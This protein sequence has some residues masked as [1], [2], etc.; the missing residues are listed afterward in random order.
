SLATAA[1]TLSPQQT[2]AGTLAERWRQDKA[3][4]QQ[5]LQTCEQLLSASRLEEA[6]A[7]FEKAKAIH[8]L[9]PPVTEIASMGPLFFK[10][11][12]VLLL[13]IPSRITTGSS[14]TKQP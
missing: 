14:P 11:E 3:L 7:V 5:H 8:A 12:N 10:A 2:E 4:I 6:K 1:A 13:T 9:Y